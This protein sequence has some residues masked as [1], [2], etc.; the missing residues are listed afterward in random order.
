[1]D[2]VA[3]ILELDFGSKFEFRNGSAIFEDG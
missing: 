3:I 2:Y 1:M